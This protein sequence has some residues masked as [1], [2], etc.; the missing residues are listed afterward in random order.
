VASKQR[1]IDVTA[2]GKAANDDVLTSR[3][4]DTDESSCPKKIPF[5][6]LRTQDEIAEAAV[7]LA[8]DEHDLTGI[9]LIPD[10]DDNPQA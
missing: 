6:R 2:E 4:S 3:E 10:D 7:F 5:G 8:S 1:K 9:E